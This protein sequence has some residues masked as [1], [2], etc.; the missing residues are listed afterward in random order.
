MT[1]TPLEAL[2]ALPNKWRECALALTPTVL[3]SMAGA[4]RAEQ[5]RSCADQLEAAIE[6]L[7]T[8][9]A[10]PVDQADAYE[11]WSSALNDAS[12]LAV[13]SKYQMIVSRASRIV[14][15]LKANRPTATPAT[16]AVESDWVLVPR[17]PTLE[18]AEAGMVTPDIGNITAMRVWSHMIVAAPAPEAAAQVTD[19]GF[20]AW[21]KSFPACDSEHPETLSDRDFAK[22]AWDAARATAQGEGKGNG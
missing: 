13:N 14:T 12:E 5:Y 6:A 22:A 2:R 9:G 11:G 10:G 21:W 18:M 15:W 3:V 7:A 8:P 20:D 19:G 17:L 16:V 1:T 4:T